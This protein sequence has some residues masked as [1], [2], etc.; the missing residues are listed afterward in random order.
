MS[1]EASGNDSDD[2]I[3]VHPIPWRSEYVSRMF[4]KIDAYSD[5]N[6]SSQAR[7]QTKNRIVGSPSTRHCP[8][9]DNVPEWATYLRER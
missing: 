1:S 5:K 7:R 3:I 4:K 6:K 9:G 8:T 2:S